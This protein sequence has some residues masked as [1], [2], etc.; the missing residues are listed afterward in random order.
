M[1]VPRASG[2]SNAFALQFPTNISGSDTGAPYAVIE[3]ANPQNNGLPIWGPSNA[4]V[5]VIR[6]LK[7]QNQTGYYAQFWWS[8][9]DTTFITTNGY[10]GFHPYPQSGTNAGTTHYWEVTSGGTDQTT[11]GAGSP[12]SVSY[13]TTFVQACVVSRQ[14]ANQKTLR[15]YWN[16]PNVTTADWI[17]RSETNTAFGESAP[18]NPKVTIGDSPWFSTQQHERAGNDGRRKEGVVLEHRERVEN[19]LSRGDAEGPAGD[20][21]H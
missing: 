1:M 6:R 11:N 17:E 20:G 3:F 16:L 8:S 12:V 9:S 5:T 2:I 4:G 18:P 7:V 21:K 13:G 15:H 10:W 19:G 14:N